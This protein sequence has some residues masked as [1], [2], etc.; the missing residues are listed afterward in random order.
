LLLASPLGPESRWL[1][2]GGAFVAGAVIPAL[3]EILVRTWRARVGLLAASAYVL[4][5][6][7]RDLLFAAMRKRFEGDEWSAPV[8]LLAIVTLVVALAAAFPL[9]PRRRAAS[10]LGVEPNAPY[11]ERPLEGAPARERETWH[12]A[13]RD[14]RTLLLTAA[15]FVF[16]GLAKWLPEV[17]Q[18]RLP[19]PSVDGL[20]RVWRLQTITSAVAIGVV[21][22]ISDL[23]RKR[24][25]ALLA[26]A[27]AVAVVLQ[28]A[29]PDL[30]ETLGLEL[31]FALVSS[32]VAALIPTAY[33]TAA[34]TGEGRAG[35]RCALIAVAVPLGIRCTRSLF[36]TGEEGKDLSVDAISWA[37]GLGAIAVVL[38]MVTSALNSRP[39]RAKS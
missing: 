32:S 30:H 15:T 27:L 26:A 12:G 36:F 22:A 11:R 14:P 24:R 35:L 7:A 31:A 10:E 9:I 3:L 13:L 38:L 20:P 19:L 16:V 39:P 21:L 23:V 34:A 28:G 1:A 25:A 37:Y 5:I 29:L 4:W 17:T 18:R 33:L 8:R 6:V 2:F